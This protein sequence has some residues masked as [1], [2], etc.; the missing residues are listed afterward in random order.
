MLKCEICGTVFPPIKDNH[1]ISRDN[2][3]KG[4]V[5]GLSSNDEEQ[6]YDSFDCPICGCQLIAQGR[7]R[8]FNRKNISEKGSDIDA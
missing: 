5:A 7:K 1:Y 8:E 2:G 3:K 4:F 6:L